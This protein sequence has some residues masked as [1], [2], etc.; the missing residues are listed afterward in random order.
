MILRRKLDEP[1]RLKAAPEYV[2]ERC[3]IRNF[4]EL[5]VVGYR[6]SGSQ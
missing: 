1:S 5:L 3:A 6:D 4:T 2:S